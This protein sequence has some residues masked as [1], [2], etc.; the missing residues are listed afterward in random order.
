MYYVVFNI[1]HVL[2]TWTNY[3][4]YYIDQVKQ[5]ICI[6]KLALHFFYLYFNISHDA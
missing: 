5:N 3:F 1:I 2:L 4:A 6:N